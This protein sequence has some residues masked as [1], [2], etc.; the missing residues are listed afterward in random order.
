[1]NTKSQS[2]KT[3]K[4]GILGGGQLARLLALEAHSLGLPIH[5]FCQ[6]KQEPAAQVTP[7][8]SLF[9]MKNDQIFFENPEIF[10]SLSHLTFESEFI[11]ADQ[12]KNTLKKFKNLSIFPNL[13]IL[14]NIQHRTSQKLLINQFK[15]PTAPWLP[16]SNEIELQIASKKFHNHFILKSCQGGYDGYGTYRVSTIKEFNAAKSLLPGDFI[17]EAFIPF[18]RELAITCVRSFNNRIF[19]FPIVETYQKNNRCDWV[20]GP[21]YHKKLSQLKTKIKNFLNSTDYVGCLTFELFDQDNQLLINELA[22]RVHNSC[23]YSLNSHTHNQF[24]LHLLAGL[25]TIKKLQ[26]QA[27]GQS[28]CMINL[29]GNDQK[30]MQ[31]PQMTQ[32]QLHWYGKTDPRPGRKMGHINYVSD[33]PN[34]AQNLLKKALK[35]RDSF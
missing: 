6:S 17:A 10:K 29:L 34:D 33:K 13:K 2:K 19:F 12:L 8:V 20:I 23:H 14:K 26:S 9:S 1:M 32:G 28:F 7:H 11:P 15:L 27:I 35:E 16:V 21:S 30:S 4:I 3:L 22:P 24:S 18:K 25:K 5:I 31:I